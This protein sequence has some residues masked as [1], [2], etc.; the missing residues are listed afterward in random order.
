MAGFGAGKPERGAC[1]SRRG[2]RLG[3]EC[4]VILLV[5]AVGCPLVPA[6]GFRHLQ[7]GYLKLSSCQGVDK[8]W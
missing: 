7:L 6:S 3:P 8:L 2:A 1:A 4:W 5:A